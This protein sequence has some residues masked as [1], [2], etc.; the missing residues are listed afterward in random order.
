[1][2]PSGGPTIEPTIAPAIVYGPEVSWA[3]TESGLLNENATAG[4]TESDEGRV[5]RFNVENDATCGGDNPNTQSGTATATISV[6][7]PGPVYLS[8]T[9]VGLGETASTGFDKLELALDGTVLIRGDSPGGDPVG[10]PTCGLGPVTQS[11]LVASPALIS[12]GTHV[13]EATFTT[14]DEK[15]HYGGAFYQLEI[16]FSATS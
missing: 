2:V 10:S 5:I 3:F 8:Y 1:M 13:L 7:S 4:W 14:D 6:P 16:E 9:I 15:Y 12:A 11:I